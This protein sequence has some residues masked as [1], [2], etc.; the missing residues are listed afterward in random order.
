MSC[1]TAS[2]GL[3]ESTNEEQVNEDIIVCSRPVM[4]K[5]PNEIVTIDLNLSNENQTALTSNHQGN[6]FPL[7]TSIDLS[8]IHRIYK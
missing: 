7:Y 8:S 4:I 1:S 5:G 2:L 6:H 3:T